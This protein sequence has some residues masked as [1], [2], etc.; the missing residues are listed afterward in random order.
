M[1]IHTSVRLAFSMWQKLPFVC[2]LHA[3][4]PAVELSIREGVWEKL[5]R[6]V[7]NRQD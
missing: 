1:E 7:R 2:L 4:T 5:G 6:E 3:E